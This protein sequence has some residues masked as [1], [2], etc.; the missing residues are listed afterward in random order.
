M[1]PNISTELMDRYMLDSNIY[2]HL[3]DNKIDIEKIKVL[4]DYY[5]TNIQ[6]SEISNIK[7]EKRKEDLLKIYEQLSPKKILLRSGI[8]I[9]DLR[10]DD[11]QPW[12]DDIQEEA[13][14]LLGNSK[15]K[16]PWKDALIGEIAKV[17]SITLVSNDKGFRDKAKANG[18]DS[19]DA[20]E[21]LK[22]IGA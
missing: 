9:D 15:V 11:D 6:S 20:N 8:W 3:L 13:K 16:K 7:N 21:F 1:I 12:V 18:I 17:E 4:G 5:S 2:D 10:W 19:I 22:K 14:N